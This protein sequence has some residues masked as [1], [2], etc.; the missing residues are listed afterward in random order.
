MIE[1]E[2]YKRTQF[3]VSMWERCEAQK[4]FSHKSY[5]YSENWE[6]R[7]HDTFWVSNLLMGKKKK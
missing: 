1:R 5:R 2:C 4:E 7:N 6:K 3:F